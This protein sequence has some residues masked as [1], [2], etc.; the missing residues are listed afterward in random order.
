L[1]SRP[2]F[3]VSDLR[4][5]FSSPPTTRRVTV[6]VF[7]PASTRICQ[8]HSLVVLLKKKSRHGPHR[9][10]R[11]SVSVSIVTFAAIHTDRVDNIAFQPVHITTCEPK[12]RPCRNLL[13]GCLPETDSELALNLRRNFICSTLVPLWRTLSMMLPDLKFDFQCLR[14]CAC[15]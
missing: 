2:Y 6:E 13:D 3:T 11:Y 15:L 10:Q 1:V 14:I 9:K 4:L 5:P 12:R 7:D 8:L